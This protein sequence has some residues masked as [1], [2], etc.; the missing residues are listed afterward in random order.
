MVSALFG[1]GKTVPRAP[2]KPANDDVRL[3]YCTAVVLNAFGNAR[4]AGSTAV[5]RR[6]AEGE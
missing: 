4:C 5:D 3:M 2:V 6:G 1:F